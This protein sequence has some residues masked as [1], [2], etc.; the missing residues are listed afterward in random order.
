MF[1]EPFDTKVYAWIKISARQKTLSLP[2]FDIQE[3]KTHN[4]V[5]IDKPLNSVMTQG[6]QL[7]QSL[8]LRL[9]KSVF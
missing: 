7:D 5:N 2:L 3:K 6:F 8:P 9:F 4:I 1:F